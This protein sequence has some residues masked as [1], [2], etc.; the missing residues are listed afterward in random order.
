VVADEKSEVNFM[1]TVRAT[2]VD[3]ITQVVA[4]NHCGYLRTSIVWKIKGDLRNSAPGRF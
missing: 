4:G 3:S 2:I 1:E